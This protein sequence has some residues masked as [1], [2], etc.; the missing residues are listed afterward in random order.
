MHV[1]GAHASALASL[2][3][4]AFALVRQ[5]RTRG[6]RL[7]D[8]PT[9]A[10]MVEEIRRQP[11]LLL[12][13]LRRRIGCSA[14]T[15]QHHL[16]MLHEARIIESFV[17]NQRRH[18]FPAHVTQQVREHF[19]VM[20]RRTR[21]RELLELVLRSPGVPAREVG[22]RL[23]LNRKVVSRYVSDLRA[24]GLIDTR[25][26]DGRRQF[27]PTDALARMLGEPAPPTETLAAGPAAGQGGP[28][29]PQTV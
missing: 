19:S 28:L 27:H 15:A 5:A 17:S 20:T 1:V 2:A 16:A 3:L 6:T 10:R 18:L 9:R 13:D 26:V 11:G 21:S 12:A 7:L 24:C 29:L 23:S 8:N 22:S 4:G 14:G 25:I